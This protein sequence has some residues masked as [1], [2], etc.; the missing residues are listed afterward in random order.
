MTGT[1]TSDAARLPVMLTQLRL[2]TIA[3]LWPTFTETADREGWPAA[4]MLAALLEHELAERAQRRIQRHLLEA[5][6]PPGK[7]LDGFDFAAVSDQQ[8]AR[9]GARRRRCLA[10]QRHQHP[11][12][13]PAGVGKSHLAAALGHALIEN[14]YR[15]LFTRTTDWSSGCRQR[16]RSSGSPPPSRS[17]TSTTC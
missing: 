16:D 12:V 10:R 8:G 11:A 7:T 13:R 5:R 4:R 17:S 3:R 1:I 2:P 15:V 9:G 14:G 6:L